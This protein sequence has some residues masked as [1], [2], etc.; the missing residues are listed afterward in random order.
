[1]YRAIVFLFDIAYRANEWGRA[2]WQLQKKF[3]ATCSGLDWRYVAYHD[4]VDGDLCKVEEIRKWVAGHIS[5]ARASGTL[6]FH[7]F[8]LLIIDP[9]DPKGAWP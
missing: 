5:S 7:S 8:H 4:P 9:K 6:W 3:L 2:C 1:M